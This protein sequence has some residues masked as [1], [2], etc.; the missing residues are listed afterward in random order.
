[1]ITRSPRFYTIAKLV[2]FSAF[3]VVEKYF[4]DNIILKLANMGCQYTNHT[5]GN[6]FGQNVP[7][8][9][10]FPVGGIVAKKALVVTVSQLGKSTHHF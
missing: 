7:G 6:M 10:V 3:V 5:S 1:M 4:E 2:D 8:C 9:V